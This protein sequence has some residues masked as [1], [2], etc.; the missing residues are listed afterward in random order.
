MVNTRAKEM[1]SPHHHTEKAKK[2]LNKKWN[3]IEASRKISRLTVVRKE[4]IEQNIFVLCLLQWNV[5]TL[6]PNF[7][8]P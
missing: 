2:F 3:K 8:F 6:T 4:R 7:F 5:N 1:N